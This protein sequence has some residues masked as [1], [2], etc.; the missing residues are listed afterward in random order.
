MC[1]SPTQVLHLQSPRFGCSPGQAGLS[2]LAFLPREPI[3][4]WVL[5]Y[6]ISKCSAVAAAGDIR[7]FPGV[8]FT[9]FIPFSNDKSIQAFVC[10]A[11]V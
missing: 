4:K 6:P 9:G 10:Q 3:S 2:L 11:M 8:S 7:I 5:P 1:Q